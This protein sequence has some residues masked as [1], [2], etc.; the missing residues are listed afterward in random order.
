MANRPRAPVYPVVFFY[1]PRAQDL[2]EGLV[3][4]NATYAALALNPDDEKD[5]LSLWIEQTDGADSGSRRSTN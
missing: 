4:N 3:K 2:D 1:T 5:L